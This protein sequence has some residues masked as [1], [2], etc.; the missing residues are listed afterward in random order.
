M[1]IRLALAASVVASGCAAPSPGHPDAAP[2]VDAIADA[3]APADADADA[4][5][6]PAPAIFYVPHQ[7][8][9]YLAMALGIAEHLAA[10]RP[11]RAILYTTGGN[12]GL[13]QILRGE[14]QC[15]LFGSPD[16]AFAGH[17]QFHHFD[18]SD[19]D[20]ERIRTEEFRRAM[21][22]LG[23]TDVVETGWP[24]DAVTGKDDDPFTARLEA[25]IL[26]NE[27]AH[28]GTSHKCVSGIQ[29]CQGNGGQPF[30]THIA[31][32]YAA[33]RLVAAYP[34]GVDGVHRWD[35]R[36]Y[37]DY[38]YFNPDPSTWTRQTAWQ[39]TRF[40]PQKYAAFASYHQWNPAAGFYALGYHSV[41]MLFDRAKD[42]DFVRVESL[43][44]APP[45]FRCPNE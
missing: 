6:G 10:G 32:W 31:C 3:P 14:A 42:D 36:F 23:V 19:A 18:V 4:A 30:P 25:L 37:D 35:F 26:A 15:P 17:E 29:D 1:S 9:D 8:D 39:L 7:D 5:P 22:A 13:T 2:P 44:G 12:H 34:D 45:G 41:P 38:V 28:P 20:I 43:D 11:V 21:A 40:M 16:P 24:D 33:R 27:R